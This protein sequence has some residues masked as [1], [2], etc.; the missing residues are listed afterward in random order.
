MK[1]YLKIS[2]HHV[3]FFVTISIFSISCTIPLKTVIHGPRN[4]TEVPTD[5]DPKQHILLVE[6][7][8]SAKTD[9]TTDGK[10]TDKLYKA[11]QKYYPYRFQIVSSKEIHGNSKKYSD[12]SVY[13][14]AL[15]NEFRIKK[16]SWSLDIENEESISLTPGFKID[17]IAFSFYDRSEK[18]SFPKN[19]KGTIIM[20]AAIRK[21]TA[22][23]NGSKDLKPVNKID[24]LKGEKQIVHHSTASAY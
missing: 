12:T 22:V 5:F 21:L 14:Y 4:T 17:H 7:L 9:E 2:L 23:V 13:K 15:L 10:R 24:S 3:L 16:E 8:H 20:N 18:R 1:P 19:E 11:L 6:E